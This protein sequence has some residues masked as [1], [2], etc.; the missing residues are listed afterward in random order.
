MEEIFS[1]VNKEFIK[2]GYEDHLTAGIV[3]TGGTALLAGI[4]ELAERVFQ[5][6]V[7]KG[8]PMGVSGLDGHREQPAARHGRGARGLRKQ[9]GVAA[10]HPSQ[11]RMVGSQPPK[12]CKSGFPNSSNGRKTYV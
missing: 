4:T 9:A 2:A 11:R 8:F 3:L 5:M 6:P 10:R 1:L 7:R 12:K